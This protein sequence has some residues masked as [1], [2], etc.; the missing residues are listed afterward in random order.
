MFF[1]YFEPP[2][3]DEFVTLLFDQVSRLNRTHSLGG[4]GGGG[5]GGGDGDGGAATAAAADDDDDD[6]VDDVVDDDD[7]DTDGPA[8]EAPAVDHSPVSAVDGAAEEAPPFP[9]QG[10]AQTAAGKPRA[11]SVSSSSSSST[12]GGW[13]RIA[14]FVGVAVTAVV[15]P[16][17]VAVRLV[18]AYKHVRN[19]NTDAGST[20][21]TR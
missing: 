2:Q 8:A 13:L 17:A 9:A 4:S 18:V 14:G 12:S 15:A 10:V 11:D 20:T 6:V 7:D 5:G 1:R 21:A 3:L 16:L 19:R